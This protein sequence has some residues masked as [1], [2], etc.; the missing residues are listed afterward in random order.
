[1]WEEEEEPSDI[2]SD[3]VCLI[4]HAVFQKDVNI[5]E[6]FSLEPIGDDS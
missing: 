4:T 5:T 1:M 2:A 6:R 3:T